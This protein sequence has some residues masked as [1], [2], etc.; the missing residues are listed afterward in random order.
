M[1][2]LKRTQMYFPEDM[3][4]EL[5]RKAEEEK[6]TVSDIV[7]RAVKEFLGKEKEKNWQDDPRWRMVGAGSSGDGTLSARHDEHL[8]GKK[9]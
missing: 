7:R 3:F 8:Y 2:T 4:R 1:S 6:S 5:K 9:P